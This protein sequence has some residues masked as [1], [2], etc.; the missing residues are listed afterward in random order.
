[1][2]AYKMASVRKKIETMIENMSNDPRVSKKGIM[3]WQIKVIE[4]RSEM[5]GNI[6]KQFGKK[7]GGNGTKQWSGTAN[8]KGSAKR[9][10]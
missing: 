4:A 8:L 1:M 6:N 7:G 10:K 3:D 5:I 2:T 9:K